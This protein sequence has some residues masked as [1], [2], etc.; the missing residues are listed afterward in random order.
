MPGSLT[1]TVHGE[2]GD[3]ADAEL[4]RGLFAQL[5]SRAG[6]L[7]WNGWPT[8]VAVAPAM[9]HGGPWPATTSPLHTSVGT[10]AVRRFLVPVVYQDVPEELLPPVLR[11]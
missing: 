8:G 1:A 4:V 5:E 11:A 6:R 9:Q 10:T 7:L 3:P 2:A